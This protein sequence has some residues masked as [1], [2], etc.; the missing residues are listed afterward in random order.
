[1]C[2]FLSTLRN[3]PA[4]SFFFFSSPSPPPP[5]CR[6]PVTRAFILQQ[7]LIIARIDSSAERIARPAV[8]RHHKSS[9]GLNTAE[10]EDEEE[11]EEE[12]A[13]LLICAHPF[14]ISQNG[15]EMFEKKKTTAMIKETHYYPALP[16]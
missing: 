15:D 11:D 5:I 12:P 3:Q 6:L 9:C 14:S 2:L 13:L 8:F 10:D 7:G 4:E 16:F 1:M